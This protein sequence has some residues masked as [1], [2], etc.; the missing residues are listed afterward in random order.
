[1]TTTSLAGLMY[2]IFPK[3]FISDPCMQYNSGSTLYLLGTGKIGLSFDNNCENSFYPRRVLP[4]PNSGKA[5]Q[6]QQFF[7]MS[8]NL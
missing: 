3:S 5:T 1:M 7:M 4:S 6:K 2:I 8:M